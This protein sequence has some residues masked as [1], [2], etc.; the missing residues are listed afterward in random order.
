MN[1]T[2]KGSR[3]AHDALENKIW[4]QRGPGRPMEEL[5]PHR[6]LT[7]HSA[8]PTGFEWGYRG[9]GPYQLAL[10]LLLEHGV[11][12]A[13]ALVMAGDFLSVVAGFP[14]EDWLITDDEIGM[15]VKRYRAK[16]A[17]RG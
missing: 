4:V 7:V 6:S 15:H 2:Y 13:E 5:L 9:S 11:P 17:S 14:R 3:F 8:S 16:E 12:D 10:A 1:K